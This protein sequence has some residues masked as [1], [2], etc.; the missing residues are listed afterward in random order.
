MNQRTIIFDLDG[1]LI[2]SAPDLHAAVN[3]AL[4]TQGR[5]ALDL[6]TVISFVGDGVEQ[7]VKRSLMATGDHTPALQRETLAR[8]MDSYDRNLTTLTRPY[9]GVIDCLQRL[10]SDGVRLGICTNK[11][12]SAAR[13]VCDQLDLTRYFDVISGAEVDQPKKP[14]PTSL[15][16]C[17]AR[18]GGR[19]ENAI[20]VGDSLVD[21]ATAQ[22]AHVRFH[23]FTGGYLNAPKPDLPPNQVFAD[24]S[25]NRFC[26]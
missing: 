19:V 2:H 14:D 4:T 10:K 1:T 21:L 17:I 7:L 9:P 11:P 15:L 24:W 20:Y 5:P 12:G 8:F 25:S 23:L 6:A 3:I 16:A 26:V 13:R 22:N 18:L